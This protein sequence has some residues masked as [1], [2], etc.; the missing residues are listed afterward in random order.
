M[1]EPMVLAAFMS[2]A[3]PLNLTPGADMKCPLKRAL[4]RGRKP[5][6]RRLTKGS[7]MLDYL[8]AEALSALATR[9]TMME[10]V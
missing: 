7:G 9:L 4:R 6:V 3:L 2:P 10:R 1:T 5:L 8:T